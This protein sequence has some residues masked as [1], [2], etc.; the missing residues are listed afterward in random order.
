M[1]TYTRTYFDKNGDPVEKVEPLSIFTIMTPSGDTFFNPE[2]GK[3][4]NTVLWYPKRQFT[5]KKNK[6]L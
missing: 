4:E 6:S 2:S 5:E 3:I 1:F